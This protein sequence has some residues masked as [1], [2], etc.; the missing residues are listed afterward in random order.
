MGN[1]CGVVLYTIGYQ[2]RTPAQLVQALRNSGVRRLVDVRL[3]PQ[4]RI[5]GFS[6]MALFEQ[7]RKA[8]IAYEHAKE[9]GNPREIRALFHGG[10]LEEGRQRYRA[11]LENGSSG[12]VDILVGLAQVQPTAI[13]CMEREPG[14]CHRSVVADVAVE[15]ATGRIRVEHL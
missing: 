10:R 9:L 6:L 1:D 7:L 2:G 12:A 14:D 11:F 8:G 13:L 15:R 5:K 4:S 3:Q